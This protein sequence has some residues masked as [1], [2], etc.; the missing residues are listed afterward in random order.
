MGKLL[1]RHERVDGLAGIVHGVAE[2]RVSDFVLSR[3]SFGRTANTLKDH[4]DDDVQD[5]VDFI[6][7]MQTARTVLHVE[8]LVE[9]L[10][11]LMLTKS[12]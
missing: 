7:R 4:V 9:D 2:K 5:L 1:G 6:P 10:E 12:I 11:S 8:Y 3:K